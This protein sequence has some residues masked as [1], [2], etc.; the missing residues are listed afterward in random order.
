MNATKNTEKKYKHH[1]RK[2]YPPPNDLN[3]LDEIVEKHVKR[4]YSYPSAATN[5]WEEHIIIKKYHG[6]KYNEKYNSS[7][8]NHNEKSTNEDNDNENNDNG[9]NTEQQPTL[10]NILMGLSNKMIKILCYLGL[11]SCAV[12]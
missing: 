6:S 2:T 4:K 1:R 7:N 11:L 5:Y 3:E 9:S 8:K 10:L 12:I